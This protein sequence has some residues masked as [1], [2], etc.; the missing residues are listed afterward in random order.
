MP[1]A[2]II[3]TLLALAP[4]RSA[5]PRSLSSSP[6]GMSWSPARYSLASMEVASTSTSTGVELPP[7]PRIDLN[8]GGRKWG[9]GR[10]FLN[11]ISSSRSWPVR[12]LRRHA[13][14]EEERR[15][16][17]TASGRVVAVVVAGE[18]RRV[19]VW[20]RWVPR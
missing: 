7:A 10:L 11:A 1:I 18:K 17:S 16:A 9:G 13:D 4:I 2:T 19:R 14:K 8:R 12:H 15:A 20:E 6:R 5:A 3:N